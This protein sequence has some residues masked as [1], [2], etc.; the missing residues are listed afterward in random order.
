MSK[1]TYQGSCHCKSV[2]YE[3]DADLQARTTKCNCSFCAKVRNW[4]VMVKPGDFRLLTPEEALT[5]Y[6]FRPESVNRHRFCKQC[7]V[8]I[9][10]AGY[11]GEIG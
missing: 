9:C 4:T 6:R 11:V 5:D 3:I 10:A 2:K 1:Q 7:G 8:R